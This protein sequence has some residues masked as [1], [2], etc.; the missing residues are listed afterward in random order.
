MAMTTALHKAFKEALGDTKHD[1]KV[2][3]DLVDIY[4]KGNEAME[5]VQTAND[6]ISKERDELKT[7]LKTANEEKEKTEKDLKENKKTLEVKEAE[8]EKLK[9]DQLT[10]EEK[11]EFL[12]LKEKG[13]SEANYNRIVEDMKELKGKFEASEQKAKD[14]EEAKTKADR[15]KLETDQENRIIKALGT[16]KI[17][18]SDNAD[19][20]MFL[21]KKAGLYKIEHKEDGTATES[22]FTKNDQGGELAATLDEMCAYIAGKYENL[23][24]S[25]GNS[26][27][28]HDHNTTGKTNNS[29]STETLQDL[30]SQAH[31]EMNAVLKE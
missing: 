19:A 30:Q 28:G 5:K 20:A 12:A 13:V 27:S 26:G 15:A 8:I 18:K 2:L 22:Y 31:A 11:K 4:F 25:S 3:I 24:D 9:T 17:T 21:A 29:K 14:A 23:V 10:P 16:A 7:K 1:G 6:D